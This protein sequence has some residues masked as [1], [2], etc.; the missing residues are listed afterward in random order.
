M[1]T[2]YFSNA[3]RATQDELLKI[4]V[5]VR[6]LDLEVFSAPQV[7]SSHRLDLGTKMLLTY[8]SQ[9]P[10]S[11]NLLDLGCGWGPV[12]SVL[13]S[14]SPQAQVWAVDVNQR[15]LDLTKRNAKQLGLGNI[16]VGT[17]PQTWGEV[18]DN[19]V[20]FDFICSNPPVRIGK[21]AMQELT[22][23]W[24]A[25]LAPDGEAW[26]VMAKNL[27]ADSYIAWLNDQG[28]EAQKAHSKKGYRIIRVVKAGD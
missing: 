24:L 8:M 7:F 12:S 17:E 21:K 27:G 13:A 20:R 26:L 14:L 2:H 25:R 28:L 9:P 3:E 11:G 1:N 5:Q 6:G 18:T 22:L 4:P 15:A 19:D 10:S 16:R 23:R